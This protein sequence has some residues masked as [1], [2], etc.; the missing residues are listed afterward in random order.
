VSEFL[1]A[2]QVHQIGRQLDSVVMSARCMD[3]E[4]GMYHRLS[5]LEEE[6]GVKWFP[7]RGPVWVGDWLVMVM[8]RPRDDNAAYNERPR[9]FRGEC[10]NGVEFADDAA[11]LAAPKARTP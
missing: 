3:G 10:T 7:L 4:D 2:E 9:P 11:A 8:L 5:L 6:S 1:T